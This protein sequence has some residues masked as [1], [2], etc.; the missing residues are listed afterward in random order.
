MIEPHEVRDAIKL[1][2]PD[3]KFKS[4]TDLTGG[5]D[6]VV[7]R[8]DF[9]DGEPVVFRGQRN[10]VSPYE[11]AMDFGAQL[12]GEKRFYQRVTHLPVP[13]AQYIEPDEAVLGF[14]F[15]FFTY[16]PGVRLSELLTKTSRSENR[17]IDEE[18]G[19][20]LTSV[21]EVEMPRYGRLFSDEEQTW[22][23]YFSNRLA[24]R[25]SPYIEDGIVSSG[26]VERFVGLASEIEPD[27]PR[28]LHM[29]FRP[30]NMLATLNDG[31]LTL[32]GIVDAANCLAG[33]ALFDLARLDEGIGLSSQFLKGYESQRGP[34]DRMSTPFL[35]YRLET[36]ALLT[37]VYR[38]SSM[39]AYRRD[40][41]RRLLSDDRWTR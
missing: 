16:M 19:R 1:A 35:L 21:H 36:A 4:M 28:L 38:G 12:I 2:Y 39:H 25:I 9:E 40:R 17:R 7:H 30:D 31:A 11:G 41:L 5:F 14:P 24:H 34:V 10:E 26:Q 8:V 37:W 3:R 22:G 18:L 29:D 33:D 15:G 23:Q 13:R 6:F 27:Y 32:T 20:I